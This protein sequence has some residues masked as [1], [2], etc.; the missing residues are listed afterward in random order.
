MG[1]EASYDSFAELVNRAADDLPTYLPWREKDMNY[2]L[3]HIAELVEE[4]LA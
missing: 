2:V 1:R 4:V 3:E